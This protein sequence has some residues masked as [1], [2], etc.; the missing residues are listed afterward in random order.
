MNKVKI[1]IIAVV[2]VVVLALI[3]DIVRNISKA[4]KDKETETQNAAV[5]TSV[6]SEEVAATDSASTN[7]ESEA[8]EASGTEASAETSSIEYYKDLDINVE[9]GTGTY[10]TDGDEDFL[11]L[12]D[13]NGYVTDFSHT[14]LSFK[15]NGVERFE[16]EGTDRYLITSAGVTY[17]IDSYTDNGFIE[18]P[19]EAVTPSLSYTGFSYI[20]PA[21][22]DGTVGELYDTYCVRNDESKLIASDVAANSNYFSVETED[23]NIAWYYSKN[24][25]GEYSLVKATAD[26]DEFEAGDK[27]KVTEEVIKEG[28]YQLL[29]VYYGDKYFYYDLASKELFYHSDGEDNLIYTGSYDNYYVDSNYMIVIIDGDNMYYYQG[30]P[31]QEAELITADGVD[32]MTCRGGITDCGYLN[33]H[34][35]DAGISNTIITDKAGNEYY[36]A[37]S[38]LEGVE[39]VNLSHKIEEDTVTVYPDG[40]DGRVLYITDGVLYMDSV[41][42]SGDPQTFI[43]FDKEKVVDYLVVKYA[44]DIYLIVLTE[45]GNLYKESGY[46]NTETLMDTGVDCNSDKTGCNMAYDYVWSAVVYSKDGKIY[47]NAISRDSI[48]EILENQTGYFEREDMPLDFISYFVPTDSDTKK[49]FYG[50]SLYDI[51]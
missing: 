30:H 7:V 46:G 47:S 12:L 10:F 50:N 27:Y 20:I 35:V 1:I 43:V 33:G 16:H 17:Y 31:Q 23:D 34:Y 26:K 14:S 44:N 2:A 36:I 24:T 22:E 3:P 42:T 45:D 25:N 5:E 41:N 19:A 37:G 29:Y 49:F 38:G 13:D 15:E 9:N 39:T 32:S 51:K 6:G 21:N 11:F 4:Q 18:M 40:N 8:A 48:E 28:E